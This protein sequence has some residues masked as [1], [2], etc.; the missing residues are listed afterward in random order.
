MKGALKGA[1]LGALVAS[2]AALLLAPKSG[3]KTRADLKRL[4]DSAQL[5]LQK[6]AK[7]M[8]TMSRQQYE[9][10]FL[11]SL[12]HAAKKKEEIADIL[13]DVTDVLKR[14]WDEV[15]HEF[16]GTPKAAPRPGSRDKR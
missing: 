2:A 12:A 14:G 15:K 10:L 6:K 11:N 5:D 9:E 1:A 16:K 3:K 8:Q 7:K 13:E 4:L